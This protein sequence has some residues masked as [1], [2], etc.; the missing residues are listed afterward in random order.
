LEFHIAEFAAKTDH[1]KMIG[2]IRKTWRK[3]SGQ[4][5]EFALKLNFAPEVMALIGEALGDD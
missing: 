4:G 5:H 3:M 2:I 1:E